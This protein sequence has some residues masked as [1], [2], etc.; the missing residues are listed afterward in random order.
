MVKELK[1]ELAQVPKIVISA[2]RSWLKIYLRTVAQN[3]GYGSSELL[4]DALEFLSQNILSENRDLVI[5]YLKEIQKWNTPDNQFV[6]DAFLKKVNIFNLNQRIIEPDSKPESL[7][8]E[9]KREL[10]EVHKI[11]INANRTWLKNFLRNVAR[12]SGYPSSELLINSLNII[13]QKILSENQDLVTTELK[14]I[15]KC[16]TPENQVILANFLEKLNK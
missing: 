2:N 6:L 5:I 7:V 15:Q 1:E 9:L 8:K 4:L 16:S 13:A 10:A 11:V 12:N 14:E 3:S